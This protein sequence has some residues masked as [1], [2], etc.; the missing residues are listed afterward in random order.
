GGGAGKGG[1]GRGEGGG[2]GPAGGGAPRVGGGSAGRSGGGGAPRS[3]S[4]ISLRTHSPPL[5]QQG[6]QAEAHHHDRQHRPEAVPED[7]REERRPVQHLDRQIGRP[8][9]PVQ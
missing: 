3:A 8:R 5:H 1:G 4:H 9:R 7:A 6:R 2:G